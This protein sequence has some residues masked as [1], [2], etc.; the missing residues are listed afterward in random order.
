MMMPKKLLILASV[1]LVGVFF[2]SFINQVRQKSF[3]SLDEISKPLPFYEKWEINPLS[4]EEK[5]DLEEALKQPYSYLGKGAQS[6]A[7]LSKDGRYVIKFF[8]FKH[9]QLNFIQSIIP[10]FGPLKKWKINKLKEKSKKLEKLFDA[11]RLAFE[12]HR[13]ESALVYVHLNPTEESLPALEVLDPSGKKVTLNLDTIP[14]LI[15]RKV[16]ITRS[17]FER[18][19][20]A[21]KIE[22]VKMKINH[23]V[24]LYLSEYQK[25]LFDHDHG[26]MHNT[27]FIDDFAVHLDVGKIYFDEA[28]KIPENAYL[29]LVKIGWKIREHMLRKFPEHEKEITS[30]LN[31][32]IGNAFKRHLDYDQIDGAILWKR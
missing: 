24:E 16:E 13:K 30:Y 31:T 5:Q 21:K 28:I 2:I 6:F 26:V 8:K 15:Q 12:V 3:F 20:K 29:D 25:G 23:I 1:A 10:E 14:F 17:I 22:E 27:G 4:H 18:L 7:F 32:T 11:Y 9:L 19:L